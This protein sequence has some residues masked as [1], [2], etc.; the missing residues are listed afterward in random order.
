MYSYR[1]LLLSQKT[2]QKYIELFFYETLLQQ[3]LF[4]GILGS[5]SILYNRI[6]LCLFCLMRVEFIVCELVIKCT[7]LG[8]VSFAEDQSE[9]H[10]FLL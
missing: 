6:S 4:V 9:M 1:G 5:S 2:N 7:L 3:V 10:C 8:A